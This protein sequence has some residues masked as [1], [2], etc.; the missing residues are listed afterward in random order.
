MKFD[1]QKA[2]PYPVLRPYSDDYK[3][4]DFQVVADVSVDEKRIKIDLEYALS[5]DELR[6]QIG[7]RAAEYVSV[8]SCRD[9]Y[10]R[11]V[12]T[13]RSESA[14]AE[15]EHS[16]LRGEV[17]INSYIVVKKKIAVFTAKDI[18]LEFGGGPFSFSGGDILAQDEPQIFYIDHDFFKPVTSVF[19]LVKSDSLSG[20]EWLISFEQNHVQ[21][22]VSSNM[23]ETIDNARNDR[24]N[25]VILINS[26][27]FAAAMQAIQKLMETPGE[28]DEYKWAEVIKRQAHNKAIDLETHDAYQIAERLLEHP[29]QLLSNFIFQPKD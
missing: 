2:F 26:I 24:K 23:K 22:K 3:E 14:I 19:D 4:A 6:Y 29:L 21:I 16:D 9:T 11:S 17:T 25:K 20:G 13:S 8:I 12:V 28:Y 1:T 15:F 18:N 5:S 27:Y 10:F 7:K